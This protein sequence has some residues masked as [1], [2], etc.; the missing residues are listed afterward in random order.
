[1]KLRGMEWTPKILK[2]IYKGYPHQGPHTKST[3]SSVAYATGAASFLEGG[4]GEVRSC[5]SKPTEGFH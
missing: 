3:G 4:K 1:M 5:F 2:L